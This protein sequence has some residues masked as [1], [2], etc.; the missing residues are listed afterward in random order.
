MDSQENILITKFMGFP[1]STDVTVYQYGMDFRSSY[2]KMTIYSNHPPKL[3][4]YEEKFVTQVLNT[5]HNY[6]DPDNQEDDFVY[7]SFLDYEKNWDSLMSVLLKIEEL[8]FNWL[9]S[10]VQIQISYNND[11]NFQQN[12]VNIFKGNVT[13]NYKNTFEG[14]YKAIIKFINWY[15]KKQLE[16][17]N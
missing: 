3:C 11:R 2:D 14:I 9:I 7:Q 15:N 1:Y 13:N 10:D 17:G 6:F 5:Y 8:G 4:K 16:N 12:I